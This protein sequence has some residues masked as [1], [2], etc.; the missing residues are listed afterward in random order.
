MMKTK[1][2]FALLMRCMTAC[3]ADAGTVRHVHPQ[4]LNK[5]CMNIKK[6]SW[7][8][9]VSTNMHEHQKYAWTSR[10]HICT[11]KSTT[12]NDKPAGD[13]HTHCIHV[14]PIMR[15]STHDLGRCLCSWFRAVVHPQPHSIARTCRNDSP[16]CVCMSICMCAWFVCMVSIYGH[17]GWLCA[18]YILLTG[19]T[20]WRCRLPINLT[21][22]WPPKTSMGLANSIRSPSVLCCTS[23]RGVRLCVC[24]FVCMYVCVYVCRWCATLSTVEY[25]S[26]YVCMYACR[27]CATLYIVAYVSVYVCMYVCM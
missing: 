9:H 2:T 22:I 3:K 26:V 25:V 15:C 4:V 18:L 24:M 8:W 23:C 16:M 12:T 17:S 11:N 19:F 27:W 21:R 5:I 20:V 13:A 10:T 1:L 7:T 6:Y 14:H